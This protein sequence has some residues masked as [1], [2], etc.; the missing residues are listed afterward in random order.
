MMVLTLQ[1]CGLSKP[2]VADVEPAVMDLLGQCPLWSMS[3]FEKTDGIAGD[4]SYRLDFKVRL[5]LKQSAPDTF[6]LLN[7][8]QAEPAY[9]TCHYLIRNLATL[10]GRMTKLSLKYEVSAAADLVKSEKGWRVSGELHDFDY[11]P[12]TPAMDANPPPSQPSVSATTS[13]VALPVINAQQASSETPLP[14]S[15]S[16]ACVERE[17]VQWRQ[18]HERDIDD[19]GKAAR[20]KGE[21]LQMSAGQEALL[22]QEAL[23]NAAGACSGR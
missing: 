18:Q 19:A 5:V 3:D 7:E 17:I 22:E 16:S 9:L 21:E 15:K 8:H 6:R 2:T 11:T 13:A 10:E 20:A 12:L 14:Q 4:A 23:T 1:A